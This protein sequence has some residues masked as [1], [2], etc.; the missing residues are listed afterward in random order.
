V[1]DTSKP[2]QRLLI[3]DRW[4]VSFCLCKIQ[5]TASHYN[6][7]KHSELCRVIPPPLLLLP[8]QHSRWIFCCLNLIIQ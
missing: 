3:L 1:K 5:Q 7:K 6:S 4:C 2:E 8:S